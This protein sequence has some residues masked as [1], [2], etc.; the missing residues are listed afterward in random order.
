MG[1]NSPEPDEQSAKTVEQLEEVIDELSEE[2][3]QLRA[4]LARERRRR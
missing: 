3:E 4:K 1:S 2:N